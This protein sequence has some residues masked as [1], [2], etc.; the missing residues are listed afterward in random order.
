MAQVSAELTWIRSI[1]YGFGIQVKLF[2]KMLCDNKA[3]TYVAN[4]PVFYERTKDIEV[5]CHYICD[6]L[7]LIAITFVTL[8]RWELF[9]HFMFL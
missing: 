1:L 5:D 7:K 6:I 4:N 8:C 9:L 2:M 3:V